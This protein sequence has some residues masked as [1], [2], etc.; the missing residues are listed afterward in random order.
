MKQLSTVAVALSPDLKYIRKPRC[1]CHGSEVWTDY[2]LFSMISRDIVNLTTVLAHS[3]GEW[4]ASDWSVCAL[5]ETAA[6]HPMGAA[7][8]YARRYALFTLVGIAGEDDLDAP[9]LLTP[10]SQGPAPQKPSPYGNGKLNGGHRLT[11]RSQVFGGLQKSQ[12]RST[13]PILDPEASAALRDRLLGQVSEIDS[14]TMRQ[15]RRTAT[16]LPKIGLLPQMPSASSRAFQAK[17]G[18]LPIASASELAAAGRGQASPKQLVR[19]W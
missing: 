6:P 2:P 15:S 1:Q 10:T 3:S 4:V 19:R 14:A 13:K 11:T 9:D 12:P 7:L 17:P 5:T 16:L 8:T 18:S